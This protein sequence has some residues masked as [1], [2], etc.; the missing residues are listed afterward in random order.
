MSI[1]RKNILNGLLGVKA[2]SE[3]SVDILVIAEP[4]LVIFS[5]AFHK[6]IFYFGRNFCIYMF[7]ITNF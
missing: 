2:S 6:K 7:F 3:T 4:E 5:M 1:L